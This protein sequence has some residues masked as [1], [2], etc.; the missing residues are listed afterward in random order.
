MNRAILVTLVVSTDQEPA[1]MIATCMGERA[2][3]RKLVDLPS[4]QPAYALATY[5]CHKHGWSTDLVQGL[6][7]NGDETFCFRI[8]RG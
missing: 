2:I 1:K 5:L 8:N 4:K 3:E 6:L 7:P